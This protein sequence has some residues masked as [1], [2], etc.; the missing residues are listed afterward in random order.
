M[1]KELLT[2]RFLDWISEES[3][4]F[5]FQQKIYDNYISSHTEKFLDVESANAMEK[6]RISKLRS[7]Y[8]RLEIR[9]AAF[10]IKE[11][12]EE[13]A[14][15][16]K[17]K[18][19]YL[20]RFNRINM[21]IMGAL[22]GTIFIFYIPVLRQYQMYSFLLIL[23][24]C[25]VPNFIKKKM[26]QKWNEF[27]YMHREEL[28]EEIYEEISRIK[29][30]IQT[31]LDDAREYMLQE[32]FPLQTLQ[33]PLMS[34]DYLN[35]V[36]VEEKIQQE[37]IQYV[38]MF[39]YPEDIDPFEVPT[40]I[41][42][43]G[44]GVSTA[45]SNMDLGDSE[46]STNDKFIIIKNPKYKDDGSL[47]TGN[48]DYVQLIYKP[49]AESLLENSSFER[50]DNPES[51]IQNLEDFDEIKCSCGEPIIVG[52]IQKVT[53]NTHRD[54]KFYLMIGEKCKKCSVNPFIL[55]ILPDMDVP[56]DLVDIFIDPIFNEAGHEE[57]EDI[58]MVLRDVVYNE[59]K[60]LILGDYTPVE[61]KDTTKLDEILNDASQKELKDP[62]KRFPD[63]DEW[64][65]PK[66]CEHES[67]VEKVWLMTAKDLNKFKL[68]LFVGNECKKCNIRNFLVI[69]APDQE[70]PEELKSIF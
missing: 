62:K 2:V 37:Q 6:E 18:A 12:S 28:Q 35:L 56:E 15:R 26:Q 31:L 1:E 19:P 43:G 17:I 21:I 41:R 32:R 66:A 25:F 9:E 67:N 29:I 11:K 44:V 55:A 30:F 61:L 8:E 50:I 63:I 14:K 20:K 45:I 38:F 47:I 36:L 40:S 4:D 27:K 7:E 60:Q 54:F 53:P 42:P 16:N 59:E 52:E 34:S 23:P 58:I 5:I 33:F 69:A 24:V 68:Y 65:F 10:T 49:I 57:I 39:E 13:V 64:Q 48:L 3:F 46:D 22:I 70:I 51:V